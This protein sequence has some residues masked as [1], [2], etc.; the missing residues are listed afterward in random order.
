MNILQ[1]ILPLYYGYN[2]N[3]FFSDELQV[4]LSQQYNVPVM[5][6]CS[7]QRKYNSVSNSIVE[8]ILA[9]I[10]FLTQMSYQ[11]FNTNLK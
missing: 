11:Y 1:A 5:K 3:Y 8:S 4:K 9:K 10:K 7:D 2:V 6:Y